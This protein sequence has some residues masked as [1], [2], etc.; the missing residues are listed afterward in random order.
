LLK[1]NLLA[2]S[3]IWFGDFNYRIGLSSERVRDLIRQ[4]NIEKL[5]ENDQV[6]ASWYHLKHLV[7]R[8]TA[9]MQLNLQMVAGLAFRFYSEARIMF[10]PTYRFDIGTDD[11]DT[12]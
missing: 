4:G 1:Q 8:L 9:W 7:R 12:S 5:Y 2:D 6:W 10:M 11:Y 3:V